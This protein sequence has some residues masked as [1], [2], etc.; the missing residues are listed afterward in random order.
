MTHQTILLSIEWT[1]WGRWRAASS[2]KMSP[3]LRN[4]PRTKYL[5][6]KATSKC[7]SKSKMCLPW[8]TM[9]CEKNQYYVSWNKKLKTRHR[10][11]QQC[12]FKTFPTIYSL[13]IDTLSLIWIVHLKTA[14][15]LPTWQYRTHASQTKWSYIPNNLD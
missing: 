7:S 11:L 4:K 13:D 1:C 14:Q 8:L 2:I 10:I 3:L 9:N 15:N 12:G 6:L 5:F